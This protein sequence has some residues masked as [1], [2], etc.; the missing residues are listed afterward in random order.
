VTGNLPVNETKVKWE[1]RQ[2]Y[3]WNAIDIE[4]HI[5][6]FVYVSVSR[7]SFDVLYFMMLVFNTCENKPLILFDGFYRNKS[8]IYFTMNKRG[9]VSSLLF[10]SKWPLVQ[11]T[12]RDLYP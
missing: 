8:N 5:V 9:V 11:S 2:L 1:G 6:L 4:G 10:N 7:T 12:P 3:I